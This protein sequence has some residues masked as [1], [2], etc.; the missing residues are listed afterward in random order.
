MIEIVVLR[1]DNGILEIDKE[2][3]KSQIRNLIAF[4]EVSLREIK[5]MSKLIYIF[6]ITT[7]A[8]YIN[9]NMNFGFRF[10]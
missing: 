1:K 8:K 9:I 5:I 6:V 2:T 10:K 3:K 4:V 7:L